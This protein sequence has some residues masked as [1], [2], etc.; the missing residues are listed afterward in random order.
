MNRQQRR[1]IERQ[2]RTH[3]RPLAGMTKEQRIAALIKNGIT[4]EDLEKEWH[5][6]FN[7]GWAEASPGII[8][9]VYAAVALVLH[10]NL[11]FGKHRICDF[12]RAMDQHVITTMSSYE[13]IDEVLRRAGV[14]MDFRD[15][16]D[17]VHEN[18]E[19][20]PWRRST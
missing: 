14:E 2:N 19:A 5:E 15:P 13:A 1:K 17:R 16:L 8:R 18:D 4:V 20:K 11:R 3:K 10:D 12:L 9:T 6:G 7:A